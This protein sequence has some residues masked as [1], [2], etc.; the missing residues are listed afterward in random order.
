MNQIN[1]NQIKRFIKYLMQ[2][3]EKGRFENYIISFLIEIKE[4]RHNAVGSS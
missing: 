3:E 2:Y 4:I 1:L